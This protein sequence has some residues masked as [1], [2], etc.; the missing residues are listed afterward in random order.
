MR[1]LWVPYQK[2]VLMG[3]VESTAS[4]THW[5]WRFRGI[6]QAYLNARVDTTP[7][8]AYANRAAERKS[9]IPTLPRSLE[10]RAARLAHPKYIS[11][12]SPSRHLLALCCACVLFFFA[13]PLWTATQLPHSSNQPS[14][15][16]AL[17]NCLSSARVQLSAFLSSSVRSRLISMTLLSASEKDTRFRCREPPGCFRHNMLLPLHLDSTARMPSVVTAA[18]APSLIDRLCCCCCCCCCC[19]LFAW[20]SFTVLVC[21]LSSPCWSNSGL[22]SGDSWSSLSRKME[23]KIFPCSCVQI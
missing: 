22:L 15:A 23:R 19:F 2:H 11:S 16:T 10:A 7:N 1:G 12:L 5:P 8:P 9:V 13:A 6:M 14:M 3:K 17:E 18:K 20:W 21:S 4:R